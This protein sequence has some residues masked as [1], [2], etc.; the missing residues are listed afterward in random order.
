MTK[1]EVG[2]STHL[3]LMGEEDEEETKVIT[4]DDVLLKIG[5]FGPF[6]V[7]LLRHVFFAISGDSHA[8]HGLG[9]CRCNTASYL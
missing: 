7:V 5:E 1:E 3:E 9:V 2:I 4:F 8:T 6:Q